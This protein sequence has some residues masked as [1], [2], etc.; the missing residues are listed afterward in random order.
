MSHK[1]K[2]F[3]RE[4]GIVHVATAVATPRANGQVERYNRTILS[5]LSASARD[6]RRWDQKLPNVVWGINNTINKATGKYP[7]ELLLGFRPRN[8]A[9]SR[10]LN[11]IGNDSDDPVDRE[12]SREEAAE[13][14]RNHSK[15]NRSVIISKGPFLGCL[16]MAI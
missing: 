6:N 16:I 11:A 15:S 14:I 13:A 2:D 12:Q 5:M 3:C 7:S 4:N 8:A 1:F 9:E 10:I